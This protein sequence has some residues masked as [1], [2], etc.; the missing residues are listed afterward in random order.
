MELE[1][2]FS[3][4]ETQHRET[5]LHVSFVAPAFESSAVSIQPGVTVEARE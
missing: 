2:I 5:K 1:R 3:S 4:E